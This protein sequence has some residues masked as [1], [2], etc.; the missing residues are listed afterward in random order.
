MTLPIL[1]R[2]FRR[3]TT[4]KCFAFH[5]QQLGKLSIIWLFTNGTCRAFWIFD[6]D[7]HFCWTPLAT[8]GC[9]ITIVRYEKWYHFPND[10]LKNWFSKDK[11]IWM[12]CTYTYTYRNNSIFAHE[13]RSNLITYGKRKD[14]LIVIQNNYLNKFPSSY[15]NQ[16][17]Y[18]NSW[19][20][21]HFHH[22][23]VHMHSYH[24]IDSI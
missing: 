14:L 22:H 17:N 18:Y 21:H 6:Q 5:S 8:F 12:I 23:L 13:Q 3:W 2:I 7:C 4:R 11:F 9:S 16:H 24:I 1:N 15:Y 20:K 19:V 10:K